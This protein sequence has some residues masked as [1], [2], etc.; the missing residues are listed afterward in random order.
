MSQ[1]TNGHE[2]ANGWRTQSMYSFSEA[3]H[4]ADVSTTTVK[5]WLFGYTVKGREVPPLFPSDNG[6]MVSFLQMI[7]IMVAGRFRKS[8]SRGR[9]VQFRAVRDAHMNARQ[10]SGI[11]YPFAHMK[12]EALGG[13]IVHFLKKGSSAGSFQALDALEQWSLP[14]LLRET[15]DQI[16]YDH[17]HEL[18][19]RWFPIG[20]KV[21]IV[22]DPRLSAGLPVI[23][24]RGV[25]VQAIHN[26]FFRTGLD[27]DFIAK[28]FEVGTDLVE[29]AIRYGERVA[30]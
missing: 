25:T 9:S 6:D 27:I 11:E 20:K 8:A 5:N 21:P 1:V 17:D 28:D 3:A 7:E 10:T 2:S 4:L 24:G 26:R 18:A 19:I 14:G 12:L 15:M 22:V 13:H 30:A 29:T 23:E 16:D